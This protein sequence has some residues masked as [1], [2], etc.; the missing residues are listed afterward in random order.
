MAIMGVREYARHRSTGHSTVQKA[1]DSGR[2]ST[3]P[4]GKIDSDVAD[5]EWRE[6]T[7]VRPKGS[8][9]K[10]Q[11]P[12][13]G[14]DAVIAAGYTKS[15]AVREFFLARLAEIEY[16]EKNGSLISKDEV[17]I[18]TF[19]EHRAM[20]DA[21]LNLPDRLAAMLAAETD[22]AKVYKILLDEIRKGLNDYAD[23]P[24]GQ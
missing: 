23:S 21:M 12:D 24:I 3:L 19:N 17:K 20:R 5:R 16:K 7:E 22:E 18:A 2:I 10:R 6:N 14:Q 11:P 9:R 15:R 13:G 8:T 4:N 1:I